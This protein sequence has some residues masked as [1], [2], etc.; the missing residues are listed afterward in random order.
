[1]PASLSL[2]LKASDVVIWDNARVHGVEGIREMIEA[3]GAELLPLPPCSP[4]LMPVEPGWMK[5]RLSLS[6]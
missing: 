1:M 3:A 4:D 2:D 5:I 6:D